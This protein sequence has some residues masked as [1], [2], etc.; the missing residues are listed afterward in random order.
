MNLRNPWKLGESM[1]SIRPIRRDDEALWLELMNDM[2][3]ATRYMRGARK[4]EDLRAEDVRR[5]VS[6]DPAKEVVLVALAARDGKEKMAGVVRAV[7]LR[8]G[9]WEFA[10][11]VLDEW[12]RRGVGRR[13]MVAL[14]EALQERQG[15]VIEGDVLA[16][17]RNM[18]DFVTRLGFEIRSHPD[19]PNVKRVGRE[20]RQRSG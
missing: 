18:L 14:L 19:Q 5:A 8:A 6:P 4:A 12:Q 2:S 9:T 15:K 11:V 20:L 1:L 17:N 3:W 10:L 7:Q 13:L 16:S